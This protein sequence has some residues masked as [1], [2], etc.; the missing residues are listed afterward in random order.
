MEKLKILCLVGTRPEAIKFM[1]VIKQL[2]ASNLY[3]PVVLSTGQHQSLLHQTFKEVGITPDFDLSVMTENQTP[4]AVISKVLIELPKILSQ[5]SISAILVQGDTASA[6]AGAIVGF[7]LNIPV[8]HIE[9]GLRT[10]NLSAPYPEEGLRQMIDRISRWCFAPTSVSATNLESERI[11]KS[12]IHVT[13][14]TVIDTIR[15]LSP[16]IASSKSTLTKLGLK[17]QSKYILM[18]AHRRENHGQALDE[19]AEAVKTLANSYRELDIIYPV[20]P[21][22][23]VSGPMRLALGE[24]KNIHLIDPLGY[25]DFLSI[26]QDASLILSDSGGVQEEASYFNIPVVLLRET[27]ERPEGIAAGITH[28]AGCNKEKIIS[29]VETILKSSNLLVNNYPFGDGY[30]AEKI[31]EI[32]SQTL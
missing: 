25:L 32:I 21:N 12:N 5:E 22:P 15:L 4:A 20:H 7:S 19:V 29:L 8:G 23:N 11:A 10:Y 3:I 24:S 30:A 27:T 14:N 26:M 18:T 2:L 13:G 6:F 31:V 28:M 17:T 16:K 9:A 1:P